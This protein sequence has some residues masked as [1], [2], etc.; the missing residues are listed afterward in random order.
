MKPYKEG[1]SLRWH[2]CEQDIIIQLMLIFQGKFMHSKNS[3][4]KLACEILISNVTFLL[5]LNKWLYSDQ[6]CRK[7]TKVFAS[8]SFLVENIVQ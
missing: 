5:S 7:I 6:S 3:T 1:V 2:K 8:R 4:L